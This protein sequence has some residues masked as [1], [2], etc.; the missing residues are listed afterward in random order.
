MIITFVSNFLNHHQLVL[1]NALKELCDEFYFVST[2]RIPK[3]RLAFGYKEFDY[4]Y[5]FV[6]RTYDG[7]AEKG[8][9]REILEKSDAVIFGACP[10]SFIEYRMKLNKLSFLFSERFFKKGLWRRFYPPTREKVEKRI[11]RFKDKNIYVLC[12]SAFLANELSLLDFPAEKCYKWGYFPQTDSFDVYPERHNNKLKIL[13]AGRMI[14]WKC[15]DTALK[16][17]SSLKKSGV[18]FQ[19][20]F[21]GDGECSESLKSLSRKLNLSDQVSFSGSKPSEEVRE[22]MADADIFLFT[23]NFREGWGAVLN[24]AMS[25][26][27]AVLA[28]SAAGS[29]PFLIKDGENGLIY[30]YGSQSDFNK[31]LRIL[32]EDKEKRELLGKNAIDTIKN[33]YSAD[34]AAKRLVEFI[35]SDGKAPCGISEGPMSEAEIIKNNWYRK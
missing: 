27:C 31:K 22:A 1:C 21:I 17:C 20:E 23:S 14:D 4:E 10:D 8:K 11:L 2:S 13:W 9:V 19:L 32:A 28:S 7:S 24:E 35:E 15:A 29:V 12:A 26:G 3:E 34:V 25:C 5:D 18:D 33:V 30:K 16:A 6:V